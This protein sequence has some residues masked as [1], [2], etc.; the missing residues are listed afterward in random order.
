MNRPIYADLPIS[1]T[2][3]LRR[4]TAS[5]P[6]AWRVPH[7]HILRT[8]GK[9]IGRGFLRGT[10]EW[11]VR[12]YHFPT[13]IVVKSDTF[14]I[15]GGRWRLAL[16]PYGSNGRAKGLEVCLFSCNS[17]GVSADT[18]FTVA[19]GER[20]TPSVSGMI[21]RVAYPFQCIA[22]HR[23]YFDHQ[24][25]QQR[26][27]IVTADLKNVQEATEDNLRPLRDHV[28]R[29]GLEIIGERSIR[30]LLNTNRAFGIVSPVRQ[31]RFNVHSCS[32]LSLWAE[33]KPDRRYWICQRSGDEN[34]II[35]RCL[36]SMGIFSCFG[37]IEGNESIV[38]L[39]EE[40]QNRNEAFDPVDSDTV[41][42]FVKLYEPPYK[43]LTYF[44]HMQAQKTSFF[45]DLQDRIEAKLPELFGRNGYNFY[46]EKERHHLKDIT[47]NRSTVEG[48]GI[49][50]G[51]IIIILRKR[52]PNEIYS[53]EDVQRALRFLHREESEVNEGSQVELLDDPGSEINQ[54]NDASVPVARRSISG[55]ISDVRRTDGV[56]LRSLPALKLISL[57][58]GAYA[59]SSLLG[60][61]LNRGV[62]SHSRPNWRSLSLNAG[63][64]AASFL[65]RRLL[66]LRR[67]RGTL[68][69]PPFDWKFV[70]LGA[71]ACA[72]SFLLGRASNAQR[73][74]SQTS[75]SVSLLPASDPVA[76][77]VVHRQNLNDDR[78]Q[79]LLLLCQASLASF[80]SREASSPELVF[81]VRVRRDEN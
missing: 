61:S 10:F 35:Q 72:F 55:S 14:E 21:S 3:W 9:L 13:N 64:S 34:V 76:D 23:I 32:S 27:L 11:R 29:I 1:P 54:V 75:F 59:I 17:E 80:V 40:L 62:V 28:R 5:L 52:A 79:A 31:R 44:G 70:F 8:R 39:F 37:D 24:M 20:I 63:A 2:F 42:I 4:H 78:I 81:S 71:G 57:A 77:A 48:C 43:D 36:N 7:R 49:H 19:I 6:K 56:R 50:S 65:L 46:L 68:A 15:S 53:T 18:V 25:A 26:N 74:T 47:N 45:L 60:E 12:N 22:R 69:R 16:L 66:N 73:A 38:T 30:R 51:S 67:F 41:I 33:Q 58:A